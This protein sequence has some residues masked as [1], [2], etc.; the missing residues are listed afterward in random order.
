MP[1]ATMESARQRRE[2]D[3]SVHVVADGSPGVCGGGITAREFINGLIRLQSQQQCKSHSV[4]FMLLA[5]NKVCPDIFVIRYKIDYDKL[6]RNFLHPLPLPDIRPVGA[7]SLACAYSLPPHLLTVAVGG[8]MMIQMTATTSQLP[9]AAT[10]GT[11]L[12]GP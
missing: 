2:Q 8:G 7:A 3:L 11:A 12:P 1:Y 10:V 5:N 9:A 6:S 4:P